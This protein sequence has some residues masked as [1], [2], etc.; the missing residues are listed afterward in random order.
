MKFRIFAYTELRGLD[1]RNYSR[2]VRLMPFN[3]FNAEFENQ[4]P[5]HS[6]YR[7]AFHAAEEKVGKYYSSYETFKATRTHHRK[8]KRK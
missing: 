1:K 7:S 3:K 4:L 5:A 8:K 6:N 2:E